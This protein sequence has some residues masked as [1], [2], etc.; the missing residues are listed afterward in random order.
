MNLESSP[1]YD[2]Y[3]RQNMS[4][5]A[6]SGARCT[7]K[8]QGNFL[9]I[10]SFV[11]VKCLE[12]SLFFWWNFLT[13]CLKLPQFFCE[14]SSRKFRGCLC[15]VWALQGTTI[16]YE[17]I[18]RKFQRSLEAVCKKFQGS[19]LEVLFLPSPESA[20]ISRRWSGDFAWFCRNIQG[21]VSRTIDRF[22]IQESGEIVRCWFD[23][24]YK[25]ARIWRNS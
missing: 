12:T 3:L 19:F 16:Q 14:T 21:H 18:S 8:F 7:E 1:D 13:F 20:E 24:F 25:I 9:E 22:M 11:S 6:D 23:Y 2:V 10:S 4:I 15:S 5:S 17:E